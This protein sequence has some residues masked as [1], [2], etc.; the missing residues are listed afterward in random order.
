MNDGK[1]ISL[2]K[3]NGS[4]EKKPPSLLPK[5]RNIFKKQPGPSRDHEGKFVARGYTG[6]LLDTRRFNWSRALPIIGVVALVGGLL[7]FRSFAGS[8]D[9]VTNK[10][11]I[12]K[13]TQLTGGKLKKRFNGP[14]YVY[15]AAGS[16][17][18][19]SVTPQE[20][21]TTE[22]VCVNYA[23][24]AD[25]RKI[26]DLNVSVFYHT[27]IGN[28]Q[29]S[30][31]SGAAYDIDTAQRC[32]KLDGKQLQKF[33]SSGVATATALVTL[34]TKPPNTTPE[35]PPTAQLYSVYGLKAQQALMAG[36]FG[37]TWT[38]ENFMIP[39]ASKAE[40][41]NIHLYGWGSLWP[42]SN[43]APKS[44]ADDGTTIKNRIK[45]A[46]AEGQEVMITACCAPSTYNTTGKAW[47]LDNSR[48][49]NE[50]EQ[51]YANRVADLVGKYPEIK[52]VQVWNEFKGYWGDNAWDA[53]SYTRFYNKV[54]TA[55]KAKRPSV[56]VGGGYVVFHAKESYNNQT[57]NGVT[58]DKRGVEALQ[59]WL[60]NAKGFDAIALDAYVQPDEFPKIM[61][62][63]RGMN[64][65]QNKPLWW[66][67]FY[68]RPTQNAPFTSAGSPY[69]VAAKIAPAMKKGDIALYWAEKKYV[70]NTQR[71]LW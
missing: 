7:V 57:Y 37:F 10:S 52:Y 41:A 34:Q 19:A 50:L 14:D 44:E 70:P 17:V 6:G 3:L 38:Q 71:L 51:T 33:Q 2:K 39:R 49:K 16:Q 59:Y 18:S 21:A 30:L 43:D 54:Y 31:Q 65:A 42:Y 53:A 66:S 32:I 1:K 68:N 4:N 11:F 26:A 47:D 28:K 23:M 25:N 58:L 27:K 67:E 13:Q 62:Y 46:T 45:S 35:K 64:K 9:Q 69:D 5:S 60:N 40:I 24:S 8:G 12:K 63:V 29:V 55:V 15:I 20:L 48:V 61:S 36:K 56:L 22:A